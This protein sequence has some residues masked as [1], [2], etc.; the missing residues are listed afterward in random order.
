MGLLIALLTS[1]AGAGPVMGHAVLLAVTGAILGKAAGLMYAHAKLRS[2]IRLLQR[3]W[4]D[5]ATE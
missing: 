1:A 5:L 2:T 3:H 4:S